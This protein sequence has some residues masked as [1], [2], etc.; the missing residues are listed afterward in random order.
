[1]KGQ[2]DLGAD[3]TFIGEKPM[4]QI[5][6]IGVIG[7]GRMGSQHCRVY[8]GLR[9]AQLVGVCDLNPEIG[10]RIAQRFEVPYYATVDELLENVDAVSLVTPTPYHYEVAMRCIERGIHVMIEKPITETEEQALALV[11]AAER[12]GLVVQVGH[13]ERFNTAYVELKNVLE[14]LNVLAVNFRRLSVFTGSNT[15]VDVV[16]DLMIHDTDLVMDLACDEPTIVSA[17]GINV[18]SPEIDYASA[19]LRFPTGPLM[20]LTA[21]RVTEEKVRSIEV[22]AMETYVEASLLNKTVTLHRRTS[23]QYLNN[24]SHD[25]K[26]RQ[27]GVVESILVPVVEPLYSELQAFVDCVVEGKEPLVTPLAGWKALRLALQIRD[28][29]KANLVTAI[30]KHSYSQPCLVPVESTIPS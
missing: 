26:Y 21:S 28:A 16:L 6:R 20:T 11:N 1:M 5:K 10:N 8:S 4:P 25:V 13:I 15:D 22:T 19:Q 9:R 24:N 3:N 2:G 17:T 30:P 23:G 14:D 18:Y 29:C 12:S 7:L 27:E